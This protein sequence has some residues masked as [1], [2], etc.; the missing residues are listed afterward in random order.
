MPIASGSDS[1]F[2]S[3]PVVECIA[4]VHC[5]GIGKKIHCPDK[6]CNSCLT[7]YD[8]QQ[9]RT[10]ANNNTVALTII[11]GEVLRKQELK[12]NIESHRRYLCAFEDPDFQHCRWRYHD[13]NL[14][15]TRL[16]CGTVR[17]KGKACEKCW[18]KRLHKIEI[19]QYF[20]PTGLCHEESD[21]IVTTLEGTG[22]GVEG[23]DDDVEGYNLV[24]D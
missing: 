17:W 11:E 14:R 9:L 13:L 20:T 21:K 5:L 6:I 7:R 16:N 12:R 22:E 24:L 1:I 15:G 2:K 18:R 23:E 19:V 8:P 10:W 3:P 4:H